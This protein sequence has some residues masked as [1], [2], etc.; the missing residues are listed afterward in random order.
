MKRLVIDRQ[1]IRINLQTIKERAGASSIYANL[2]GNAQGMGLLEIATLL[3]NEGIRTFIVSDVSAA[4]L[5]RKKGFIEENIMMLRPSVDKNELEAMIDLN[6]I[7]TV[8]SL[9]TAVILSGIAE[10]RSTV[11][12]V[13]IRVDTGFGRYGFQPSEV[14]KI[15]SVYR[16]MSSLAITGVFTRISA[17]YGKSAM[18]QQIAVFED[19]LDRL[20]SHGLETGTTHAFDSSSLFAHGSCKFD[21][22]CVGSALLGRLPFRKDFGLHKVGY[23]EADIAEVGWHPKGSRIDGDMILKKPMRLAA[24][25]VGW[26]NGI[27]LT[28]M[29]KYR[30]FNFL[31]FLLKPKRSLPAV[32]V[33]G[34]PVSLLPPVSLSQI[35]LDVSDNNCSVGDVAKIEADPRYVKDLPIYY[36]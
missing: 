33:C 1:A 20:V 22:A 28:L 21:A 11:V 35:I 4:S 25:P 34:K 26:F 9:D 13:Q 18:E 24:V 14:D 7:C 30:R 6:V 15:V 29:H 31:S 12:E 32:S 5:L 3:R 17:L 10:A 19:V 8:S 36:I 27:D 23:I 2:S 16:N